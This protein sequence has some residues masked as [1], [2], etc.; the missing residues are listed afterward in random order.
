MNPFL[1][2]SILDPVPPQT[3]PGG[4]KL[5]AIF[6][7]VLVI[8]AVALLLL[9]L[10][11]LWAKY[12]RPRSRDSSRAS[13]TRTLAEDTPEPEADNHHR[14]RRRHKRRR[15]DHRSRNPTLAETGGLPAPRREDQ[16]PPW[17]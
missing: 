8:I 10:L 7:D 3:S 16:V 4:A 17:I 9:G 1:A 14:R 5:P 6:G 15:R 13:H 2:Q 12:L 11:M